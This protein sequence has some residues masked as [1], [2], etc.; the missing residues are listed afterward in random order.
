MPSSDGL[1]ILVALKFVSQLAKPFEQWKAFK[2]G[3]IDVDGKK[4]KDPKTPEEK[5][6][7]SSWMNLIRNVK[8]LLIK[9]PG[10]K[11]QVASIAVALAL[12]KDSIQKYAKIE[13][14]ELNEILRVYHL[15]IIQEF[16]FHKE[17]DSSNRYLI[18]NEVLA[19]ALDYKHAKVIAESE[20]GLLVKLLVDK[21]EILACKKDLI[22]VV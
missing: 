16:K 4:I 7:F 12:L 17:T 15:P 10:G 19:E 13:T 5:R 22:Q 20:D 8:R 3:L 11:S 21:K 18:T 1:S 9:V 6:Q 14:H 2:L